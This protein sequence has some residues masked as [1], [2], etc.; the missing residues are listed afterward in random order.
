MNH[1]WQ[2]WLMNLIRQD[3]WGV[4]RRVCR[5]CLYLHSWWNQVRNGSCR[6]LLFCERWVVLEWT[7][8][9]AMRLI[10]LPQLVWQ[11]NPLRHHHV[12]HLSWHM[13]WR[14]ERI[15]IWNCS[16]GLR[17][18]IVPQS[19]TLIDL[20]LWFMQPHSKIS[21][22]DRR[23]SPH[24]LLW[25]DSDLINIDVLTCRANALFVWLTNFADCTRTVS[26]S[27]IC[28]DVRVSAVRQIS[29]VRRRRYKVVLYCVTWVGIDKPRAR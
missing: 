2:C 20:D 6:Y 16:V 27:A 15:G 18:I 3:C 8:V 29:V 5:G 24:M 28:I 11:S 12:V 13:L 10:I 7:L 9:Q 22:N 4:N 1:A 26:Q 25:F 19:L 17:H 14:W 21:S 23:R